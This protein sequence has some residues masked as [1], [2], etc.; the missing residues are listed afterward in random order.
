MIKTILC[1][2]DSHTWGQG[3]DGVENDLIPS[4]M[5]G[6]LRLLSFNYG[7]YVNLLRQMLNKHTNSFAYEINADQLCK[8]EEFE[9]EN[10][11]TVIADKSLVLTLDAELLRI[12][13]L[14]Q[15]LPSKAEIWI[16]GIQTHDVDLQ[17]ENSTNAYRIIE[18][19]LH[20]G[21]IHL[22]EVKCSSGSVLVYRIEAYGGEYA[23]I[24]CGIGSCTTSH[25]TKQF[26]TNYV[27]NYKPYCI[28]MEPH[29]INDW[30]AG[31][32]PE[33]YKQ[34][35]TTMIN[36]CKMIGA[37]II[38]LTVSPIM[39]SQSYPYNSVDYSDYIESSREVANE[40]NILIADAHREMVKICLNLS[41]D[42]QN[43]LLFNDPWHVNE[44]GH[45]IYA[46]IAFEK[47]L[48]IIQFKKGDK[49]E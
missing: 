18:L 38:L 47:L 49:D 4:I 23:M 35:L 22:L 5:V 9:S 8:E 46:K 24:N 43:V 14:G 33:E 15:I 40:T 42:Q 25:F 30:L 13:F 48:K 19:F 41:V 21:G 31:A 45:Q 17:V 29:T 20:E 11:C 3:I 26:W 2:G 27:I 32:P 28:I 37:E 34:S 7:N 39:G 36:S 44:K 12:E 16:D 1:T 6:D 10:G